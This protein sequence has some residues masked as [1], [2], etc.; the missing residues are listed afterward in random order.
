M[1]RSIPSVRSLLSTRRPLPLPYVAH[2]PVHH[3]RIHLHVREPR[4]WNRRN[5]FGQD[6]EIGFPYHSTRIP[7]R[8]MRG[9]V[10]AIGRSHDVPE[11]VLITCSAFALNTL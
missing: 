6:D 3:R 7:T 9:G 1:L 8:A 2:H 11:L 4:R 10:I 5:V